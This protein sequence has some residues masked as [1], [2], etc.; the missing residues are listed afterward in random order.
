MAKDQG[1]ENDANVIWEFEVGVPSSQMG[2]EWWQFKDEF[3]HRIE[4]SYLTYQK[5]QKSTQQQPSQDYMS[6]NGLSLEEAKK[7]YPK[8]MNSEPEHLFQ[9]GCF[10]TS[11]KNDSHNEGLLFIDF[12]TKIADLSDDACEVF[13]QH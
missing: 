8:I 2:S 13:W 7:V 5:R 6:V 12:S 11:D 3:S 1:D 9:S 10:F 4:S